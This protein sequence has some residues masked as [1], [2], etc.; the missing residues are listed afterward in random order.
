MPVPYD[1]ASVAALELHHRAVMQRW[2]DRFMGS[3]VYIAP[4]ITYQ[5]WN[6]A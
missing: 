1:L 3:G 2:I 4:K 6:A 5:A